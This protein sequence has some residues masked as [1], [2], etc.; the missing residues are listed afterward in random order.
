VLAAGIAPG[1][2]REGKSL[3]CVRCVL[4]TNDVLDDHVATVETADLAEAAEAT[5]E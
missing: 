4:A 1:G 5:S 3:V 2:L